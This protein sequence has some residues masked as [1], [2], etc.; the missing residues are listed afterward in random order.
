MGFRIGRKQ[1]NH[2]IR[3]RC[4]KLHGCLCNWMEKPK[5][6]GM[7]SLPGNPG[8]IGIV[9]KIAGKRMANVEKV[10]PYL[11]GSSCLQTD[12]RQR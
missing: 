6:P 8:K 10:N 3:H 1:R 11:V 5:L 2:I 9:K 12:P 7:E 4:S